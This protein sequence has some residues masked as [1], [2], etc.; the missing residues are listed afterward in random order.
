[1]SAAGV[2]GVALVFVVGAALQRIAGMGL[3]LVAAPVLSLLLGP[4]IGVTMSNVGAI[5]AAVLVLLALHEDVD[6][7]RFARIGP[8]I[9][10]GSV[11]GAFLVRA[12]PS[13]WLD[14]LLGGSV[15]LALAVILGLQSRLRVRGQLAASTA[16]VAAGLLNT[17]SGIAG[18]ALAGYAVATGWEQRSFAATL[19]PIFLVANLVSVISKT[20]V[21]ANAPVGLLPWWIWLL[22]VATVAA[23]VG[24]AGVLA[25]RLSPGRARLVAIGIALSGGVLA[26]GRGL[27]TV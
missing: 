3:G 25:S 23:G 10:V 16:G 6:W 13:A 4:V 2:L 9:L 5:A 11:A 15:L 22:A 7:G 1:M 18:P 19:Q 14:L 21:G 12:V 20:V 27:L 26:L 8:L 24:G 17:T